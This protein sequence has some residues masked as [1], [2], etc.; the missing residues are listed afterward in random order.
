MGY[1][2]KNDKDDN[3][4][5]NDDNDK[6]KARQKEWLINKLESVVDS[7]WWESYIGSE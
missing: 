6:V 4:D 2:D 5:D 7:T 3:K 1:N